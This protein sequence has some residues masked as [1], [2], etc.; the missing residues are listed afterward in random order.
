LVRQNPRYIK[1][2]HMYKKSSPR[3][4]EHKTFSQPKP[5]VY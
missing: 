4:T 3:P 1:L 5:K 2:A